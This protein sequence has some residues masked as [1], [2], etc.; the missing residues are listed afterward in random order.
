MEQRTTSPYPKLDRP[1]LAGVGVL[2]IASTVLFWWAD[3][4]H[5]WR[6]YQAEFRQMVVE[7]FGADRAGTVPA[8]AQQIWVPGLLVGLLTI[9]PWLDRSPAATAG[10]W[11]PK[12]RRLQNAVFIGVMLVILAFTVIGLFM[13]GPYWNFYWPWEAW[14]AIPARI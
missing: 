8:G 6:Y 7:K 11:F 9:W 1:I 10:V 2:L 12:S 4:A 13:R 14:P 5:D 3:R